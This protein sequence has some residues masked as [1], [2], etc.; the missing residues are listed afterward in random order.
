MPTVTWDSAF[1]LV[2]ADTEE[3]KYGADEI[4]DLKLAISER[5]ELEMNFK[6][7]TQPLIK[8]GKAAVV[9]LGDTAA[10]AALTG[11]STGALAWDTTLKVLKR[12]SGATWAILDL[13][14][15]ALSGLADDDHTQYLNLTKAAQEL[16]ENLAV[17]ALK[18]ID[19]RDLSVDGAKLDGLPSSATGMKFMATPVNKVTW[20]GATDW[21]DVDISANTGTDT[22]IA[23]M[24]MVELNCSNYS[25]A[26]VYGYLRKNGSSETSI[27]PRVH[28][29]DSWE[30][31]YPSIKASGCAMLIVE[32]DASEIFEVKLAVLAGGGTISFKV[33]LIGYF[34]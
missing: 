1:E 2:P 9:Y 28:V 30:G 34:V 25:T 24:V 27:L 3:A 33:D 10:I 19:G 18:T 31:T 29:L 23:A 12:Y 16:T 15:G 5:L 20:T 11:M 32:C 13:D 17:T 14:H 4:R 22:A 21:T 7:G 26:D 6:T 8:A